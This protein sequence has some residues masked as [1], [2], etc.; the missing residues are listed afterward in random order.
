MLAPSLFSGL[1][2]L[3]GVFSSLLPRRLLL[4][5]AVKI[6][7]SKPVQ[8]TSKI[9]NTHCNGK[10]AKLR[11]LNRK[12]SVVDEMLDHILAA[13]LTFLNEPLHVG[14]DTVGQVKVLLQ[15]KR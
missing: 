11:D 2:S 10:P 9:R 4:E 1:D 15:V 13:Q 7:N 8:I 12:E 6:K 5:R 3:T 14:Q